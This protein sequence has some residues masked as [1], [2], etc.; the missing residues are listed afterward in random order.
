MSASLVLGTAGHIDHGKTALIRALTGVDTDRLPEEKERGI[1]IDLGFAPLDLGEGVGFSVVD[2]PGHE[3]LVRTMVAGATGIDVLLLVVAADEGVMPQTRE[4]LAICTLLGLTTGL[5]ALTKTDTVDADV[6]E[7]AAEEV[8]DELAGTALAGAPVFPV[9]AKTGA[10]LEALR[11][12][13]RRA[14]LAAAPRTDRSGRARLPVDRV[15]AMRGFGAVVTGT[16]IGGPLAVGDAVELLPSGRRAR[17]RGLQRFGES[18]QEAR[19]GARCAVNLQGVEVAEVARG[20]TLFRAGAPPPVE[21]CDLQLTWLE[22]API[23]DGPASVEFL[24]GTAERRARIAPVGGA[25]RPGAR[26]F[27]RVHLEGGAL[28]LLAGDR[29]VLRGFATTALGGSTVG[30]GTVIDAT[31]ARRRLSDPALAEELLRLAGGDPLDEAEVR[32]VRAGLV[33]V[34]EA[35]VGARSMHEV[36][37]LRAALDALRRDG[38]ADCTASGRWLAGAALERIEADLVTALDA[39]HAAEPLQEGMPRGALLGCV[40]EN[41]P[42]EATALALTRLAATGLVVSEA[43]RVRRSDHAV[44]LAAADREAAERIV[45]EAVA[46][47][48]A[49]PLPREWGERLGLSPRHLADLLGHLERS[50][51]LTRAPGDVFFDS[52]AV[53]ALRDRIRAHFREH[54]E[55]DTP[56]YK[57]LI[58][59]TRKYAVPLMEL[60]DD[61]RLT[62]RRGEVRLLRG[63][64][65]SPQPDSGSA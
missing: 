41:V 40:P 22:D 24:V 64:D 29:C 23:L 26:G 62:M 54:P 28:P 43:D 45:A 31:P 32:L 7:L 19:P 37:A 9:S 13:L 30:G 46:A 14:A 65:G 63:R 47:G 57:A 12:G 2:V 15:F 50:G 42:K 61:E 8:R 20:E 56:T 39:F 59:T 49:P 53:A 18:V 6:R 35:Q 51:R 4:H 17:I 25:L 33:G 16:L 3:G 38:R 21:S 5:V 55:L 48:L 60:F 44:E 58:G 34:E 27:A 10:G 11:V 1:T 36:A 52:A